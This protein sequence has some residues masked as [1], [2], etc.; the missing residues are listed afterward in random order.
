ML[1]A[2]GQLKFLVERLHRRYLDV[3]RLELNRQKVR[4]INSVQ[5]LILCNIDEDEMLIRDLIERG[6]Y[7]GSNISYNIRKLAD[8]GYLEQERSEHDRRSVRIRL[9]DKGRELVVQLRHLDDRHAA[10]LDAEGVGGVDLDAAL[11]ALSGL[12]RI[13]ADELSR[14]L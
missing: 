6:Y 12:E 9:T 13:Y 4:D 1:D 10:M 14:R 11:Q 8:Y 7:L 2:Y 3:L 5:A